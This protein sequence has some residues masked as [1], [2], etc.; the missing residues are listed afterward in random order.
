MRSATAMISIPLP[1]LVF[2][3]PPFWLLAP[4]KDPSM[5]ASLRS[6]QPRSRR[7]AG[8]EP[9]HGG[10][11]PWRPAEISAGSSGGKSARGVAGREVLPGG[12]GAQHPQNPIQDVPLVASRPASAVGSTR[13]LHKQWIDDIPLSV[14]QVHPNLQAGG[15]LAFRFEGYVGQV[16]L[17]DSRSVFEMGSRNSCFSRRNLAV[18]VSEFFCS[19]PCPETAETE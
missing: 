6:S 3:T 1:R 15:R 19:V 9:G 18:M 4:D 14:G 11:V 2:P 17:A 13:S 8:L 12:S 16:T 5:M 7:S 10:S